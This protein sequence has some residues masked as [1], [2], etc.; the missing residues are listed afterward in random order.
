MKQKDVDV[1]KEYLHIEVF[2]DLTS[3]MVEW[4]AEELNRQYKFT[5]V[6]ALAEED[7][8][9][10]SR[11]RQSL[12]ITHGQNVESALRYRDKVKMKTILREN[13][14]KV[15]QFAVVDSAS[16]VLDFIKKL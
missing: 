10:S 13:N 5:H 12:G 14:I 3:G 8:I 11:I 16:E 15:P 4:K 9:R 1:K 7:L 2:E 6:I